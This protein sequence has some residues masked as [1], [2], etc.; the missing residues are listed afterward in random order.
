M[1]GGYVHTPVGGQV[2]VVTCMCARL[3]YGGG[4]RAVCVC[5]RV[6]EGY[7]DTGEGYTHTHISLCDSEW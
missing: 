5:V 3:R 4:N 6:R 2:S 7:A 1:V